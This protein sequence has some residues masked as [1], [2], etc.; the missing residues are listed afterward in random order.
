M[1][2]WPFGRYCTV[3]NAT[4]QMVLAS[5]YFTWVAV[6]P[7]AV[8]FLFALLAFLAGRWLVR[9]LIAEWPMWH[10]GRKK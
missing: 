6:W 1:K 5:A 4:L 7:P 10:L 3:T 8:W 9:G 2:D